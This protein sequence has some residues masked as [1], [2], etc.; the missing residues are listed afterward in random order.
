MNTENT[1]SLT[2][3][4]QSITVDIAPDA[5]SAKRA[6]VEMGQAIVSVST[7]QEQ[8]DALAAASLLKG[9]EKR[10]EATRV[11]VKKPALE[12]CRRIDSIAEGYVGTIRTERQ[13][14]ETLAGTFQ[15]TVEQAADELKAQ[16]LLD[17]AASTDM[18][19]DAMRTRAS[20]LVE[21][22]QPMRVAGAMTRDAIAYEVTDWP[23]FVT[24]CAAH[25]CL[26]FLKLELRTSELNG[27]FGIP[28]NPPLPGLTATPHIKLHAKAS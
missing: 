5:L 1:L 16:E 2:G 23:A 21:I 4:S 17:M 28:S 19:E 18:S 26:S 25:G 6:C 27:Y 20:R 13:R 22:S 3:L 10:M 14:L 15:A 12:A 9:L 8:D 11:E 24:W 7:K